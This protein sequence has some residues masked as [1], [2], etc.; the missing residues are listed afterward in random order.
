[1]KNTF[2]II[3][4]LIISFA[5]CI[6]G[7]AADTQPPFKSVQPKTSLNPK[8]ATI[9]IGVAGLKID[10][11]KLKES[12]SSCEWQYEVTV[13]NAGPKSVT[14]TIGLG[15]YLHFGPNKITGGTNTLH[16]NNLAPGKTYTE[17][18]PIM[19][20]GNS[21]YNKLSLN[22]TSGSKVVDTKVIDLN[23]HYTA[24]ITSA[25]VESGMV[26]V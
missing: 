7:F 13:K 12:A 16:I 11:L 4:V 15:V 25:K 19:E 14:G 1:M 22:L 10:S 9:D 26:N 21:K 20:I 17:I 3:S 6:T 8:T 18:K 2:R 5:F 24:Q 23:I